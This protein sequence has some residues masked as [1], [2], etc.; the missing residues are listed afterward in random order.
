MGD[1]YGMC[2][3][4]HIIC[5][6]WV[7][8]TF[9]MEWEGILHYTLCLTPNQIG[10]LEQLL[11]SHVVELERQTE[12][13]QALQDEAETLREEMT[14]KDHRI[15]ELE[16]AVVREKERGSS[17]EGEVQALLE[18]LTVEVEKN[19]KLSSELQEGRGGKQVRMAFSSVEGLPPEMWFSGT[20]GN[21]LQSI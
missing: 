20:P 1:H 21:S 13:L 4:A 16:Q 14:F 2:I 5:L 9:K 10:E 17:V 11:S 3:S 15:S 7:G 19:T 6:R 8:M 12:D 18:K